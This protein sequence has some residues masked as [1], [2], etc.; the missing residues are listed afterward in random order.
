[1]TDKFKRRR[2]NN[3]ECGV[4]VDYE[5][6]CDV[7]M[8]VGGYGSL[9]RVGDHVSDTRT[10][11][12][13]LKIQDAV[14]AS[15][16]SGRPFPSLCALLDHRGTGWLLRDELIHVVKMMGATLSDN[17]IDLLIGL[18][19][20]SAVSEG[21]ASINH[22]E[23]LKLVDDYMPRSGLSGDLL[24]RVPGRDIASLPGVSFD[25][26]HTAMRPSG[27]LPLYASPAGNTG[28]SLD[29]SYAGTS[30]IP[31]SGY[32]LNSLGTIGPMSAI[33]GPGGRVIG[34]PYANSVARSHDQGHPSMHAMHAG[35]LTTP[36]YPI[37]GLVPVYDPAIISL[38][39]RVRD[40]QELRMRNYARTPGGSMNDSLSLGR[41]IE[42]LDVDR[43]GTIP[44]R[45]LQAL[46]DGLGVPIS[47]MEIFALRTAFG[48]TINGPAQDIIEYAAFCLLVD[49]GSSGMVP[50]M[51]T[52]GYNSSMQ[53]S[54]GFSRMAG[55]VSTPGAPEYLSD[56]VLR[57]YKELCSSGQ[58]PRDLFE[59]IDDKLTGMIPAHRFREIMERIDLLQSDRH[60]SMA[61]RDFGSLGDRGSIQYDNFCSKLE[62]AV[63]RLEA[64]L[65]ASGG[66]DSITSAGM[67]VGTTPM[68]SQSYATTGTPTPVSRRHHH[69]SNTLS[70][71]MNS[72][73]S[74][75]RVDALAS[76]FDDFKLAH[77]SGGADPEYSN[78]NSSSSRNMNNKAS[79]RYEDHDLRRSHNSVYRY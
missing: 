18:L 20:A 65:S 39:Q 12:V 41:Q 37:A 48:V 74:H 7:L 51:T 45:S 26:E 43:T 77:T 2:T 66:L 69:A 21:G 13:L 22:I 32:G 71:S 56:W 64:S 47:A 49:R 5:K 55:T 38:A 63:R 60:I 14:A 61:E 62:R 24:R 44:I 30:A 67:G 23:V 16:A 75:S 54:G 19:P 58:N 35:G 57:R 68:V 29:G 15:A 40:A 73:G 10:E 28:L 3:R 34:T 78:H 72:L 6:F 33:V 53:A 59:V 36:G 8:E 31:G 17:D 50:E 27:A 76:S 4:L 1:M 70:A 42:A 9:N 46:C 79:S 25:F 52:T 11:A